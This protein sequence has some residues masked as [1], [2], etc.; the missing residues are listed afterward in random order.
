MLAIIKEIA[1]PGFNLKE[2]PTP[3]C[4]SDEILVK[5]INASICGTDVGIV[6]WSQWANAH[7]RLP[8]I[9]GHELVGKIEK[10]PDNYTGDLSLGDLVS[11]ET[12]I[13]CGECNAC[14]NDNRHICEKMELFGI[15]RNGG[16]A[17]YATIPIR[18]TWKNDPTIPLDFMSVQEPFGNAVH[19]VEEGVYSSE[20]VDSVL[21]GALPLAPPIPI[22]LILGLGPVGLCAGMVSKYFGVKQV[23][24]VDPSK[25]RQ[26]L[27][28]KMGFDEVSDGKDLKSNTFPVVLEMSGHPLAIE[29]A[30]ELVSPGGKIVAFGLPKEK[31]NLEWG[32]FF[33]DKEVTVKG[34]FGRKIWDT[35]ER[36]TKIL[37]SGKIDLSPLITHKFP[38]K[39]F[40]KAMEIMKSGECGKVVLSVGS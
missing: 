29:K 4:L 9:L 37:K 39:D 20:K 11:S 34:V 27:G 32:K 12:H 30:N 10:L 22:I 5:V 16:F 3:D 35:W 15:S 36:V 19:A 25:Y 17:E 21:S 18:T 26:N 1:T 8:I 14:K 38:L 28:L 33:I 6:D 7:V 31:I 2:V 40:A 13:F 23:I 24:G